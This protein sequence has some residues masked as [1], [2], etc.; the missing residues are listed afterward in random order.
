MARAPTVFPAPVAVPR[1]LSQTELEGLHPRQPKKLDYSSDA[2]STKSAGEPTQFWDSQ[3]GLTRG[4]RLFEG[5]GAL[6]VE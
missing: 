2:C 1:A 5:S 3:Q 4:V 6:E